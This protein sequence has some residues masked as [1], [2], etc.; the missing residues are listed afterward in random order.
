MVFLISGHK[1]DQDK[2]RY[3]LLPPIAIDE[4]AKVMTFGAKKY[5][6]DNWRLVEDANNRYLAAMLR[7]AFAISRGELKDPETGLPHAAHV[8]CCAAFLVELMEKQNDL[9]NSTATQSKES[10]I[11]WSHHRG[12]APQERRESGL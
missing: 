6:P 2:P 5:Y 9:E 1:A 10:R 12:T 7:H 3:D 8:M 4:M 11:K